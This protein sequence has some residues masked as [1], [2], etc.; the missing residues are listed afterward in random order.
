MVGQEGIYFSNLLVCWVA[1]LL[2]SHVRTRY[3][4][5]YIVLWDNRTG[6]YI[7][8]WTFFWFV[9]LPDSWSIAWEHSTV[10][11]I[12][13]YTLSK[14]HTYQKLVGPC[15]CIGWFDTVWFRVCFQL[16]VPVFSVSWCG[17]RC[18]WCCA[19]VSSTPWP[20]SQ[21]DWFFGVRCLSVEC[22]R[23]LAIS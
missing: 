4:Y 20:Y 13:Y 14:R 1:R 5:S 7:Y 18:L 19:L 15:W 2:V 11:V 10:I 21:S 8:I 17:Y 6:C 3:S 12:S 9:G 23:V 22:H 16:Y